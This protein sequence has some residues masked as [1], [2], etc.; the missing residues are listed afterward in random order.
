MVDTIILVCLCDWFL[1]SVFKAEIG[2]LQMLG[3]TLTIRY[4]RDASKDELALWGDMIS[5]AAPP[6]QTQKINSVVEDY[7]ETAK[8]RNRKFTI[9]I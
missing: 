5:A 6:D 7:L 3:I 8:D 4:L 9:Q 1:A 2:F